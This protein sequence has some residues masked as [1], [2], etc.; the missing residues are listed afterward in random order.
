[1][2]SADGK[3]CKT[4]FKKIKYKDGS[5][6]VECMPVTGRQHQIRA[7]LKH[8]GYPIVNDPVYGPGERQ[9]FTPKSKNVDGC[10]ECLY[11]RPDPLPS[12]LYIYLHSFRY[13]S[14]EF[15]FQTSMPDW[16]LELINN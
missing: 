3:S 13:T 1:M 4:I 16:S 9:V 14:S 6:L 11:P 8:L 15:S 12:E 5:S 7:H 10:Y 2:V